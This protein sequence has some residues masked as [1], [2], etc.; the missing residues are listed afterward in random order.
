MSNPPSQCPDFAY[1][2]DNATAAVGINYTPRTADQNCTIYVPPANGTGMTLY[3]GYEVVLGTAF[4]IQCVSSGFGNTNC[5]T[6]T[7]QS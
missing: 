3:P 1:A 6:I 4:N 7:V 2:Y 5:V